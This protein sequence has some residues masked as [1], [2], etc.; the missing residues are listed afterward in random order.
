MST[1][2]QVPSQ[3]V[4]LVLQHTA[5]LFE[6]LDLVLE[7]VDAAVRVAVGCL[8]LPPPLVRTRQ[9]SLHLLALL[10]LPQ[11]RRST[12]LARPH[13]RDPAGEP[14]HLVL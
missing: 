10:L 7:L 3:F 9:L 14:A 8:Y 13:H 4:E 5:R 2:L 11:A 1:H 12:R 6:Q